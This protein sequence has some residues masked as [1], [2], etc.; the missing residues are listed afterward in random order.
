M[1][2][3][4]KTQEPE[5][6]QEWRNAQEKTGVN[7]DYQSFTRKPQ[8][9]NELIAEQYGLCVYTGVPLD[10][11]LTGV[12]ESNS[13]A[14]FQAHIEHIK[15]RV[16]CQRE[17]ENRGGE[18]GKEICE[19]MDYKNLVAALEVR[20]K[21]PAKNEV[22]GAAAKGKE[23]LPVTPIQQ[24]CEQKFS[25]EGNGNVIGIEKEARESI[26]LLRLNHTTLAGWR[27]G[28]IQGYFTNEDGEPIDYQ[29]E[30]YEAIIREM[31]TPLNGKLPEFC[32][33]IKSYA[34]SFLA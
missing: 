32:F 27:E 3:I 19:D 1:R 6:I 33:C 30:D 9:R 29:Q 21:P 25:F 20:N 17:L 12:A 8:L 31:D 23:P 22:F 7:L 14:V 16:V 2:H 18:Y 10:E 24:D 26:D 34:E 13:N 4:E 5:S 11:R 15:P 28:A